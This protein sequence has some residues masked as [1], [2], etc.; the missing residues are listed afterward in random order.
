MCKR[1]QHLLTLQVNWNWKPKKPPLTMSVSGSDAP[2]EQLSLGALHQL[3]K[4]PTCHEVCWWGGLYLLAPPAHTL[5]IEHLKGHVQGRSLS[6]KTSVERKIPLGD[7]VRHIGFKTLQIV[8]WVMLMW[9]QNSKH[10]PTWRM[11][12]V[13]LSGKEK[14]KRLFGGKNYE[15][16]SVWVIQVFVEQVS[17]IFLIVSPLPPLRMCTH[18]PK[19]NLLLGWGLWFRGNG[20]LGEGRSTHI[21]EENSDWERVS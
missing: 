10:T 4:H 15:E 7:M 13:A 20:G 11:I 3:S 12:L 1:T 5:Q 21:E 18:I 9:S 6:M 16:M 8:K 19:S 14:K 17:C 2:S